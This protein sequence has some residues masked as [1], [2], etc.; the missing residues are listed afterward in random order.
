MADNETFKLREKMYA[1][2]K[3]VSS[4]ERPADGINEQWYHPGQDQE[5]S[6][7]TGI[8]ESP[9]TGEESDFTNAKLKESDND[10]TQK[11]LDQSNSNSKTTSYGEIKVGIVM[12]G[13]TFSHILHNDEL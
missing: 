3:L 1:I 9:K 5:D 13:H 8:S 11:L 10:H 6:S 7:Q 12:Q 2:K 4:G